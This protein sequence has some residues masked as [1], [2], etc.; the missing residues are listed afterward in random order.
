ML[1]TAPISLVVLLSL[2][3]AS[4][5][6]PA[7]LKQR[8]DRQEA[9]FPARRPVPGLLGEPLLLPRGWPNWGRFTAGHDG[10][11]H[12]F[13]TEDKRV[14]VYG[15]DEELASTVQLDV[16]C[17]GVL[18]LPRGEELACLLTRASDDYRRTADYLCAFDSGWQQAW[19]WRP[20]PPGLKSMTLLW[21]NTGAQGVV[22]ATESEIVA[23]DH[24]GNVRWTLERNEPPGRLLSH[25]RLPGVLYSTHPAIQRFEVSTEGI[26]PAGAPFGEKDV[27]HR[28][29]VLFPDADGRLALLIGVGPRWHCVMSGVRFDESGKKLWTA[30]LPGHLGAVTALEIPGTPL[31]FA[32]TD[33]TGRLYV[34]DENGALLH[35][36]PFPLESEG[37]GRTTYSLAAGEL[38]SGTWAIYLRAHEGGNLWLVDPSAL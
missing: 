13:F 6:A 26:T 37:Q 23:L 33:E 21:T 5:D 12:L 25:P 35:Q 7:A 11:P 4:P 29:G 14:V 38:H 9:S 17:C 1:E 31:L 3:C 10:A 2:G 24:T 30:T 28:S 32:V 16:E 36:E 34:L 19:S 8:A 15:D 20:E 18:A 22:V 27:E